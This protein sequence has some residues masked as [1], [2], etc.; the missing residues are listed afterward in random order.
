MAGSVRCW[1]AH[2]GDQYDGVHLGAQRTGDVF[3]HVHQ[4][5]FLQVLPHAL[6]LHLHTAL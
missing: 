5:L 2:Q 4:L 3:G 1:Q 6:R